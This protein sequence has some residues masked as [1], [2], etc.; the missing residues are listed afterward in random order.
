MI[1]ESDM[2]SLRNGV[3][4]HKMVNR[5]KLIPNTIH[6]GSLM[7]KLRKTNKYKLSKRMVFKVVLI[8]ND[9]Y[10]NYGSK[11]NAHAL[12]GI[13][14]KDSEMMNALLPA[15]VEFVN[16]I[17]SMNTTIHLNHIGRNGMTSS[18]SASG[19]IP[20]AGNILSGLLTGG[21]R[22]R[23]RKTAKKPKKT[24]SRRRRTA[25]KH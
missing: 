18:S 20:A 8:N 11:S 13:I 19:L 25:R 17:Y 4:T 23:S 16:T 7:N 9:N 3:V 21:R 15:E 10:A 5:I 12:I 22:M 6:A 2:M 1:E 14:D 24:A